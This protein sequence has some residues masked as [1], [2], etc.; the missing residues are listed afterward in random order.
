MLRFA[1]QMLLV[2]AACIFAW[3]QGERPEKI[4]ATILMAM[5]GLQLAAASFVPIRDYQILD[6]ITFLVDL[7]GFV[8]MLWLAL[9]A[10]RFWPL[11]FAAFQLLSTSTHLLRAAGF[12]MEPLVYVIMVRAPSYGLIAILGLGTWNVVRRRQLQAATR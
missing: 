2:A 9:T 3:R 1:F 8:A 6:P 12:P 11:C 10:D 4:G 7:S 5:V